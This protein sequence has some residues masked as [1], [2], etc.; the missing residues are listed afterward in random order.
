MLDFY[1]FEAVLAVDLREVIGKLKSLADFVRR[2]VVVAAQGLH[3][4]DL[5]GRQALSGHADLSGTL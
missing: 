4:A 3:I 5:K 2:E 1:G